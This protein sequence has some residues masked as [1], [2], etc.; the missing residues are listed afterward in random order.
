MKVKEELLVSI[1][2]VCRNS[3][4]TIKD[5]IESILN[6]TYSNI[7]YIIVDGKSADKTIDIVKEYEE[8][9]RKKGISYRY[10][11][12]ND[13]GIYDAMN[14]GIAMAKGELIGIINSDDWYEP[15]AV[16]VAVNYY[17]K[18]KY[19][20]FYAD[21]RIVGDEKS[22]IKKAKDSQWITSRYWNHPTTFIPKRLYE[23][24]QY[25]NE[26]IHDD[27]DLILRIRKEH[28]KICVV[29]KVLAN[30]RR[31]G[32]SHEKSMKKALER[33]RIK[34]GIYRDNGYSRLYAVECFGMEI[35]KMV[36]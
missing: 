31:N 33:A 11:S 2:T 8:K 26:N 35:A 5:T 28:C 14:K 29:N 7:E 19:D 24:Y 10:I 18:E 30:F 27:W 6:Q 16:E 22:F 32:V 4:L 13:A 21:L 15:Q 3:E 34:Y 23:K 20:L 36:L 9:F 12:E 17:I 1:I 25:K